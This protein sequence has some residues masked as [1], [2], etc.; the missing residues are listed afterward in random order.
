MSDPS[1]YVHVGV[2]VFEFVDHEGEARAVIAHNVAEALAAAC[3]F[4]D[5]AVDGTPGHDL[6]QSIRSVAAP[7]ASVIASECSVKALQEVGR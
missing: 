4:L 6:V 3:S 5:N 7:G 1:G 2:E